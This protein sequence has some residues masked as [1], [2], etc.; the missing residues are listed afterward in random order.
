MCG[1][2]VSGFRSHAW[3]PL[4]NVLRAAEDYPGD[5]ER[6]GM[7]AVFYW[8]RLYLILPSD[9][10]SLA[11]SYRSG[12]D[13]MILLASLATAHDPAFLPGSRAQTLERPQAAAL[14][15]RYR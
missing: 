1:G 9:A 3:A 12:L 13:R 8:P 11:D 2:F 5:D 7:D 15:A 10:R 4:G 14:P 6:Y